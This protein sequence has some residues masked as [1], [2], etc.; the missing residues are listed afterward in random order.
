[1]AGNGFYLVDKVYEM[2]ERLEWLQG[3]ASTLYVKGALYKMS[4]GLPVVLSGQTDQPFGLCQ[5]MDPQPPNSA[6][7]GNVNGFYSSPLRP[8]TDMMTTT[9]GEKIGFVPIAAALLLQND[10]TPLL[11]RVAAGSNS[12]ASQAICAYGGSTGD[13]TGGIVYLPEQDW[14]G[15]ITS[16]AV[17]GGNVTLVFAPAAPRACTTG[18]TVSAVPLAVGS[19][20]KFASS[21]PQ[22]G[23]SNAVADV[24]AGN[25]LVRK[26]QGNFGS[27]KGS[28][29]RITVQMKSP[30]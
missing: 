21:S 5:E 2:Q 13:F 19:L 24:G 6:S 12:T 29:F 23:L 7:M 30:I 27:P 20:I 15:V 18:D 25:A 8:A 3:A 9:A 28:L 10:I 14:Q 1:M 16:S 17:S 11:N 4:A 22:L 26:I